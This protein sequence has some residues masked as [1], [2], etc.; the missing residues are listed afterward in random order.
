MNGY[1]K[2]HEE[3]SS[4]NTIIIVNNLFSSSIKNIYVGIYMYICTHI[5]NTYI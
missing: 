5:Y 3:Q 2:G 4:F 1:L